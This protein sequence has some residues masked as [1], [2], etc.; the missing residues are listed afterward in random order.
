MSDKSGTWQTIAATASAVGAT[1]VITGLTTSLRVLLVP[2]FLLVAFGIFLFTSIV[3]GWSPTASSSPTASPEIAGTGTPWSHGEEGDGLPLYPTPIYGSTEQ[4][5]HQLGPN[6]WLVPP[7][8]ER[9]DVS[10]RI[11]VA[12]PALT[13]T[14]MNA[15]IAT[16]LRGDERERWLIETLEA[17]PITT[18]IRGLHSSWHW[19]DDAQWQ[20]FGSGQ[21]DLT[22]LVYLPSWTQITKRP[23]GA[24]CGVLTGWRPQPDGGLV[25]AIRLAFDLML[26]LIELDD[27]RRQ[28]TIRHATTPPPAP[29]ALSL[30]EVADYFLELLGAPD[31][32]VDVASHLLAGGDFTKGYIGAW[33]ELSGVEFH[34]VVNIAGVT[35]WLAQ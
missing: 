3:R 5:M 15:G 35:A 1:A 9:P 27:H 17:S 18:W 32:A 4:E 24:C 30:D 12:L 10:L 29:A 19:D 33:M 2:G 22:Q 8:P 20:I 31:L 13:T 34:R 25:P 23:F 11:A 16:L 6:R 21:P 7:G 28:G 14:S 26:N